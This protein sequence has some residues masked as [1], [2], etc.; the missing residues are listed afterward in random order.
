MNTVEENYN[1]VICIIAE[2]DGDLDIWKLYQVLPDAKALEVG[3]LRVIDESGEDYLYPENNFV[4]IELPAK[5]Q[6]QLL[7]VRT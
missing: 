4:K 7:A 5:I 2:E 3:C 6:S 1:F